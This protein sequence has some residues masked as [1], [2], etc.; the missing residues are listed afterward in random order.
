MHIYMISVCF[1]GNLGLRAGAC[2]GPDLVL[3]DWELT[4]IHVPQRD[5]ILFLIEAL[6]EGAT[7]G[8]W[9]HYREVYRQALRNGIIASGQ[10]SVNFGTGKFYSFITNYYTK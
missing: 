10:R 3:I 8:E 2:H 1:S 9:C 6:Q 4:A 7:V 5:V